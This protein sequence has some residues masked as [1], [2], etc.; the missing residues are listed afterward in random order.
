MGIPENDF[1][2]HLGPG[3]DAVSWTI[4]AQDAESE[5]TLDY[6]TSGRNRGVQLAA[7]E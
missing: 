2:V 1:H 4:V 5:L 6:A 3:G 7:D